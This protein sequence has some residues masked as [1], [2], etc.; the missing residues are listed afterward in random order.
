MTEQPP[1][2]TPGELE[3]LSTPELAPRPVTP[4]Y[5]SRLPLLVGGL[6]VTVGLAAFAI[7]AVSGGS[8]NAGTARLGAGAATVTDTGWVAAGGGTA[9]QYAPGMG[10]GRMGHGPF[11]DISITAISGSKLALTTSDGWTRT[12]DATGATVTRG[13]QTIN[14]SDLK[15]G[16]H[17]VFSQTR[18]TDGT[19][20]ITAIQVVLPEVG[21]TVTAVGGS[22]LTVSQRDGT[23]KTIN[24]TSSTTYRL[25]GQASSKDAI[26]VGS[27]VEAE[28]TSNSDGSLTASLV[29]IRPAAVMG[30]V[31]AKTGSTIT[32]TDRSGASVTIK[33]SSSTQY[34]VAGK[35]SATLADVAVGNVLVAQGTRNSDGSLTASLVRAGQAG[36]GP[37]L[38]K[39]F[40]HGMGDDLGGFGGFGG[41]GPG[42]RWGQ[43]G[44]GPTA[45]PNGSASGA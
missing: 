41:F 2:W 44:Q 28:G 27:V 4:T 34:Q 26:K 35:T 13:G 11:G 5:R 42:M 10:G 12:I 24:L 21:G 33:V 29:E 38:G 19:F 30:T 17:I 39:G 37:G 14:V 25:A 43:G 31:T 22:S 7:G 9:G 1:S 45:T 16:D 36:F 23:T 32:I 3:E 15:V 20:K 18:Q 40:G 6:A 8:A